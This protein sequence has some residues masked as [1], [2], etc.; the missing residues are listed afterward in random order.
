M[1]HTPDE[2][3][4]LGIGDGADAAKDGGAPSETAGAPDAAGAAEGPSAG[5]A[6]GAT[7]AAAPAEGNAPSV[8]AC[9]VYA[10]VAAVVVVG[11]FF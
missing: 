3:K 4:P 2:Q 9:G 1:L 8:K 6:S 5:G 11:C 10:V 7:S